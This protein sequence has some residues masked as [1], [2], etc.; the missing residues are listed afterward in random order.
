[1]L[2]GVFDLCMRFRSLTVALTVES[3]AL[4]FVRFEETPD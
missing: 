4:H 3:E 1:M 2:S